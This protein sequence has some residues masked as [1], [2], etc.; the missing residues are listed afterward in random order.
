MGGPQ[1]QRG[2]SFA[3]RLGMVRDKSMV[4]SAQDSVSGEMDLGEWMHYLENRCNFAHLWC[5]EKEGSRL[6]SGFVECSEV[7][8]LHGTD[9]AHI[10]QAGTHAVSNAVA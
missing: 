6:R 10:M 1:E 7:R 5:F 9:T 2:R 8:A 3:S 4:C